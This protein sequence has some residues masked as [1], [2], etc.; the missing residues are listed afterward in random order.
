MSTSTSVRRRVSRALRLVAALGLGIVMTVASAPP[1]NAAMEPIYGSGSTWSQVAVDQWARDVASRGI[2]VNY[3]GGGSTLGRTQFTQV[4]VDFAVSEI[5]FQGAYRTPDGLVVDELKQL[6][7]R[8]IGFAYLPIVAGGTSFMYHLK[9]G[10]NL[11][12]N[13]KLSPPTIAKI[14]TGQIKVWNHPDIK[15]DNP[16]IPGL[17][18]KPIIPVVRSDGSGTSA[19][20][21]LFM[22]NQTPTI[23]TRGMTSDFPAPEGA[24]AQS[25]SDGV[26]NWVAADYGDGAITYVEYAY[27]KQ[28][29]FPVASVKNASGKYVQPTSDAVAIALTKARLNPDST[30]ELTGVYNMPD[31]RAYPVSSYSYMIVPTNIP[32]NSKFNP[33]RGETLGRYIKYFLCDGQKQVATMGYSPLPPQLVEFGYAALRKIPGAPDPGPMPKDLDNITQAEYQACPNPTFQPGFIKPID[34]GGPTGGA[35]GG[36]GGA[37][38]G[39]NGGSSGGSSGGNGNT[40]GSTGGSAASGS[41]TGDAGATS[42][43]AAGGTGDAAAGT[44][45]DAGTTG[46]AVD[47]GGVAYDPETGEALTTGG[48]GEADGGSGGGARNAGSTEL[49][50]PPAIP[51]IW[52]YVLAISALALAVGGGPALYSYLDKRRAA[53]QGQP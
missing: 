14:F 24:K 11:V 30:Q 13:L 39:S 21:T 2:K 49:D 28:R 47:D 50:G 51:A 37:S 34:K 32:A 27:A 48:E 42:G 7:D 52:L 45:G 43:N 4:N 15:A 5:P 36:N 44:T 9:V 40:G 35:T 19:Q 3:G 41:A 26:A 25:G 17:P 23:W 16:D 22:Q 18:P 33:S 12:R 1:A 20:F 6:Q 10:K 31:E 29:N 46:G 38:G 8:G 53:S